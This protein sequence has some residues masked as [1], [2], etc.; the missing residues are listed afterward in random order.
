MAAVKRW[1]LTWRGM[2]VLR[3][4]HAP[5]ADDGHAAGNTSEPQSDVLA[6]LRQQKRL[7]RSR[8]QED[9]SSSGSR[10]AS[11]DDSSEEPAPRSSSSSVDEGM[12]GS[13]EQPILRTGSPKV[14]PCI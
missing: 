13:S 6:R 11:T 12:D 2:D 5:D 3:E 14:I 10:D 4:S 1:A 7:W 8:P 9:S